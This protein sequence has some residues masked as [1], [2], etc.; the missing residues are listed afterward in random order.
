MARD[1]GASST[2]SREL[3]NLT[4]RREL[5]AAPS[6]VCPPADGRP[7]T[8]CE[9]TRPGSPWVPDASSY[10]PARCCS[11]LDHPHPWPCSSDSPSRPDFQ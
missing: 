9:G 5:S 7:A 1:A 2:S 10:P 8:W 4:K 6:A 11:R 3:E